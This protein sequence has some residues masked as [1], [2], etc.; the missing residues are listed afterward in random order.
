MLSLSLSL[1]LQ[2]LLL[3]RNSSVLICSILTLFACLDPPPGDP[4]ARV[5]RG[6][7][8]TGLAALGH[9]RRPRPRRPASHATANHDH[10]IP[11][12]DRISGS[13]GCG[14]GAGARTREGQCISRESG[15]TRSKCPGRRVVERLITSESSR[16]V[17][18]NRDV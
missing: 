11:S 9:H 18:C 12:G 8:G 14:G 4:Q 7:P 15:W 13:A 16:I 2:I 17:L 6:R 1:S 3:S 5:S 10:A